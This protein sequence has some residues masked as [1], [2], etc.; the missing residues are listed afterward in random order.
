MAD[1]DKPE[2]GAWERNIIK[3][4]KGIA[5][6]HKQID[7]LAKDLMNEI[8]QE[9]RLGVTSVTSPGFGTANTNSAFI[10]LYLSDAENRTRPQQAIFNQALYK[11]T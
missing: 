5:D 2:N 10:R 9:E 3:K 4:I 11:Q 8:P 6:W 7:D 1:L